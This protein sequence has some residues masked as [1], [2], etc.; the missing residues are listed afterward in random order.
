MAKQLGSS[1]V[2]KAGLLLLPEIPER[3]REGVSFVW[4]QILQS[5]WSVKRHKCT[6][7]YKFPP[8]L[9]CTTQALQVN[10]LQSPSY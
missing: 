7:N 9:T 10:I 2:K 6:R 4:Q 1:L 5:P 8:L 3:E